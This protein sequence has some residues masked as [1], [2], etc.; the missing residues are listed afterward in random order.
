MNP[1]KE[2]LVVTLARYIQ[3]VTC[4]VLQLT[5]IV[6]LSTLFER[7]LIILKMLKD[8]CWLYSSSR[9][10]IFVKPVQE[11][12][13]STSG[14][15]DSNELVLP[16]LTQ[17][18]QPAHEDNSFETPCLLVSERESGRSEFVIGTFKSVMKTIGAT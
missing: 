1:F 10:I 3:A 6:V 2:I 14:S 11:R 12:D 13:A 17:T 18:R 7:R 5:V 16:Q 8:L 4:I 15:V 9:M